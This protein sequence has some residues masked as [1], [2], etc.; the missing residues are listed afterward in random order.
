MKQLL[1]ELTNI[2]HPKLFVPL[3]LFVH[4][5]VEFL[6]EFE[7]LFGDLAQFVMHVQL[8]AI[9]PVV[10]FCPNEIESVPIAFSLVNNIK[11][12]SLV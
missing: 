6:V 9:I 3:S 10:E 2:V 4:F 5:V 8:Q 12:N 7:A 11:A 1:S